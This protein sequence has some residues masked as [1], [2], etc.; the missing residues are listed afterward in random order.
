[1]S[2]LPGVSIGRERKGSLRSY[3]KNIEHRW[4]GKDSPGP[5]QY[6]PVIDSVWWN[7]S[8]S[9]SVGVRYSRQGISIPK[10]KRFPSDSIKLG[11]AIASMKLQELCKRLSS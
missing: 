6:E 4:M 11:D 3:L 5:G 10:S 9:S 7:L 1:L 2:Q 8:K